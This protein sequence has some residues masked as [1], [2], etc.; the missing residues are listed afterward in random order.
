MAWQYRKRVNVAPGVYMNISKNGISTSIG[1]RGASMTF[2]KNGTYLNTGIPGTGFYN[3]QRIGGQSTLRVS[4]SAPQKSTPKIHSKGTYTATAWL[5]CIAALA[6]IAAAPVG[7]IGTFIFGCGVWGNLTNR[8]KYYGKNARTETDSPTFIVDAKKA[9]SESTD[10][11]QKRI[12]SNFI[13]TVE[14]VDAIEDEE[15]ILESLNK[16]PGKNTELISNHTAELASLKHRLE[17]TKYDIDESVPADVLTLYE[18]LCQ[19]FEQLLT[20]QKIWEQTFKMQNLQAK[21]SAGSVVELKETNFGVGVFNYIKSKFDVPIIPVG[22]QLL[23][24]Y[25]EYAVLSTSPSRFEIIDH[26]NISMI[27]TTIRFNEP[28]F[29][30]TDAEKIGTTW[31]YV[32]KNGGPDR[33]YANNRQI[34]V[35]KYGGINLTIKGKLTVTFQISNANLAE[36]LCS[37]FNKLAGTV[38][39][40]KNETVADVSE[41]TSVYAPPVPENPV[42]EIKFSL[43]DIIQ[44]ADKLFQCLV[45]M[46]NDRQIIKALDNQ[47][48]LEK[49]LGL[50]QIGGGIIDKRLAVVALTDLV[51]CFDRLGHHPNMMTDEGRAIGIALS[52]IIFPENEHWNNLSSMKSANG[53][54]F[55][56]N[57]YNLVKDNFHMDFEPDKFLL[58]EMFRHEGVNDETVNKWAVLLYRYA[59]LIAKA[60]NHLSDTEQK[61]LTN[62]LSFTKNGGVCTTQY[63][64]TSKKATL[65]PG[66]DPLFADCARQVVTAGTASTSNLQRRFSIGYNRAGKIMDQLE[67]AGVV[68]TANGWHSREVLMDSLTLDELLSTG[69]S[70]I[71]MVEEVPSPVQ[72]EEPTAT[73]NKVLRKTIS[74]PMKELENLIGLKVVKTEITNIYNLVKVQKVRASKG[75]NAPDISYHCVFTGNPGTGKTTVARLVAQI[76]KKLGIL[77]KGHLVETDRSG[78][79]AEY[80]GQ[81]AV[82][83]N[84]IID[85]ALDGVLFIDEAYSLVQN[86]GRNDY[87][88]E[89]IATLL[90][91]MEDNRDRLV[92]ILAG[93]SDRMEQFINSNPGLQSRFNRYINFEDYSADELTSIYKLNL[94]KFDYKMTPEASEVIKNVMEEA[95]AHKDKNFG[96]ARFVRNLFEKTIEQQAKRL[97]SSSLSSITDEDLVKITKEDVSISAL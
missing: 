62:I 96:N 11:R 84:K 29:Y 44:A 77:S 56:S 19:S 46:T 45:D 94:S 91:R 3:R 15:Y 43:P 58:I 93:Y 14:T 38:S 68:G 32:N 34:S 51:K 9:L 55:L 54:K 42:I 83:T 20:T 65:P 71:D 13:N 74:N 39:S 73:S 30:P 22:N 90:K 50:E 89:A 78:L 33:R 35:V 53:Q 41:P 17:S 48:Q 86:G 66:L 49:A 37:S 97:A 21:S 25:P 57:C 23:Y 31:E 63:N 28:G 7:L 82:K 72:D 88:L 85:T 87:G 64:I 81:T 4:Y 36:D 59:L 60:D 10:P 79:V 95:V 69:S 6:C 52:R 5:C 92:V 61:W 26:S 8:K 12:L 40:N 70:T 75:L 24:L 2:G 18:Q 80:V 76:Y 67:M 1:V 47:K 16:K 27:Y